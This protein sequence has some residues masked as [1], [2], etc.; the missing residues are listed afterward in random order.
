VYKYDISLSSSQNV[1]DNSCKKTETHFL[2]SINFF[3]NC[4]EFEI[5]WEN[6]VDPEATD[7]N[8]AHVRCVLEN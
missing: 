8:M 2:C 5:I 1:S 4:A 6:I 7:D 3:A